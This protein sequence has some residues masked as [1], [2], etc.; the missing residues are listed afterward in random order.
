[1]YRTYT[2]LATRIEKWRKIEK[3]SQ[4]K[5]VGIYNTIALRTKIPKK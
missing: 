2:D 4:V 3:R 1:M 5:T